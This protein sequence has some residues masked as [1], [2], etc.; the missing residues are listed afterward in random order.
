[1]SVVLK[2]RDIRKSFGETV[3][4]SGL[5][6]SLRAGEVH[7]VIG[8]N[9]AGKSTLMNIIS[10][11][12]PA[13]AGSIELKGRSYFP[14]SPSDSREKGIALIHQEL[15]I[16]PHLS[17]AENI[18]IGVEDSRFGW[19][20][21]KRLLQRADSVLRNFDHPEIRPEMRAGEL[22]S[23]AQQVV[24]ICRALAADAQI[25]LMDEP[26]SSLHRDDVRRLFSLIG[27]LKKDGIS[28]IYISHFLEEIRDIAD[29]YTVI[30]DGQDISTGRISEVTDGELIAQMV[31][32]AVDD[33]FPKRRLYADIGETVLEVKDLS[34]PPRLLHADFELRKGEILGIAG[35]VGAGRSDLVRALFN[36]E[37]VRSGTI[38]I[39]GKPMPAARGRPA[40]R[41]AQGFGYLSEDRK[42]EGLALPLS[43]ADNITVTRFQSCSKFGWLNLAKQEMQA[44]ALITTTGV[45]ARSAAQPVFTLSGGNQQKVLMARLIHQ[46]ADI[47]LLDEPTRGIDIGSKSTIYQT[48]AD[49]ADSGKGVLMISSY[50]PELFGMCDRLAVMTR[51]R[52]SAVRPISDWTPELFLETAIG[53]SNDLRDGETDG[54]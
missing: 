1:M 4:L 13:D 32:R 34:A 47:L 21:R 23:S 8:E 35:L 30:R 18:M 29:S 6:L 5:K 27:K 53:S 49:L 39:G 48:I 52:L 9:G 3:A 10:G 36:L 16:L 24:E 50:L 11:A 54:H 38:V 26:T 14:T 44:E 43:L 28:I 20:D 22:S 19:L 2:L 45:R 42:R 51:G 33:L 41:L 7:A 25:I 40:D 31:G 15:S 37:K 17:V 12:F 46:D